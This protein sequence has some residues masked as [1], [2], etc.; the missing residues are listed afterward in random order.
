MTPAWK[1][2]RTLHLVASTV[3]GLF[4]AAVGLSGSA[5]VFREEI[6]HAIYEP[7]VRVEE[8]RTPL[9]ALFQAATA[10]EPARRISMVVFPEE[11][12]RTVEFILQKREA[13]TLKEAD[14]MSVY[15]NPHTGAVEGSRRREAS[16]IAKMRDLHFAFFS[17][18]PGL[19]FNGFVALAL[20]FLSFT[21]LVLWIVASPRNQRFKLNLRGSFK[22]ALWNVHR[23]AGVLSLALLVLVS[24]TGAYYSFRDTY[25]KGIQAATGWAP[26]RGTPVVVATE[27]QA[28]HGL[29]EIVTA[30]RALMPEAR[31]AVMRI[32]AQKTQAWAATFHRAGD[33]GESTDSGPTAFLNPYT[34]EVVRLDDRQ[35]MPLGGRLVKSMEPI[36]YGKFGGMP[37]K[38]LWVIL[39]LLPL[40]FAMSGA[41]MWWNR[42]GGLRGRSRKRAA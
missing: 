15:L 9:D 8:A 26:P 6:E 1:F 41:I 31:L 34:L 27:G 39:G 40:F 5:L 32:P 22:S 24:I 30:A 21:G 28:A 4:A 33:S 16:P 37:V 17:G 20:V 35:T 2:F 12:G 13:R 23:Q 14:Q 7:I 29:E 3:F 38:L 11:P 10:V 18:P 25:L 36:H 42:T 19:T